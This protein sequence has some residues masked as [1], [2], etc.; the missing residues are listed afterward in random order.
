MPDFLLFFRA[1]FKSSALPPCA[2]I[3]ELQ[4]RVQADMPWAISGSLPMVLK[5]IFLPHLGV[6]EQD[7]QIK[8]S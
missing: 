6:E 7:V 5:H 8:A 2:T 4:D 1:A 3:L